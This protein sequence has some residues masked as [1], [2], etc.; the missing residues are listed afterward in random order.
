MNIDDNKKFVAVNEPIMGYTSGSKEKK[1]I[2]AKL[3]EM[4]SQ[5]IDIPIIIGGKEIRTN[6]ME[7]CVMPHNHQHTLATYH[8]ASS[9]EVNMAIENS[10]EAWKE[11]SSIS[12]ESRIKVFK[13][14]C[15]FKGHTE[16]QSMLLLCLVKVKIYFRQ[17]LMRHVS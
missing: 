17:K 2:K 16:I 3:Q 10:L 12:V 4:S 11:W 5:C 14:L 6:N 8:K 1:S 15:Y 7:K 13:W 9:N